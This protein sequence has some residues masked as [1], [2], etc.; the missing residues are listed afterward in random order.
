MYLIVGANGFLGSYII[1]SILEKESTKVFAVSRNINNVNK[2][3][4]N[5]EWLECDI[6]KKEQVDLLAAKINL[7]K[8]KVNIIYLAAYHHPDMVAK[9][10][11]IAWNINITSLSYFINSF[12][13][14]RCFFYPSTD[15]VYGNGSNTYHFSEN[16]LLNPTNLYGIQKITAEHIVRGYGY[17]VV[18]YPFLISP[19]IL[20]HKNHFY[21]EILDTIKSGKSMEMFKDSFR[22]SLDFETAADLLIELIERYSEQIPK[23]LNLSG[24]ED[25]SKY[26]IGLMIARKHGI[27]EEL[28]V[29]ISADKVDGIFI[30]KR[31]KSTLL[32]NSNIKEVLGLKQIKLKI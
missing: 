19:S 8:N 23:T 28:I 24:D 17:N 21:D 15:T 4:E 14:V 22:S 3:N 20:P 27:N 9:N 31:A 32:D 13:N 10:P 26:D 1:K 30:A 18:R 2:Y 25:L 16:N 5:V 29:P 7:L 11:K 6:T 12:E